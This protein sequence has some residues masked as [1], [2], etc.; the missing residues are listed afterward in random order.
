MP[1]AAAAS[2]PTV[3]AETVPDLKGKGIDEA[4]FVL[5]SAGWRCSYTGSGHVSAQSP[6]AGTK[7]AK[8]TTVNLT[9]K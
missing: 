2:F 6:K 4:L 1:K 9:L 7:A 5:E 8:G 3:Q